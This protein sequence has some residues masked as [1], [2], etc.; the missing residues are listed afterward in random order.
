MLVFIQYRFFL[1]IYFNSFFE[2]F[3]IHAMYSDHFTPTFCSNFS[4]IPLTSALQ[5]CKFYIYHIESY[6]Y[7]HTYIWV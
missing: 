5:L 1:D 7:F 3:I 4:Q 2:N 6:Y